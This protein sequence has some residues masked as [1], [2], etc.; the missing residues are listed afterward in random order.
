MYSIHNI[1]KDEAPSQLAEKQPVDM[2]C[3]FDDIPYLDCPPKC[4]QYDDEHEVEIEVECSKKSA[5]CHW[6]EEDYLQFRYDNQPLH[7]SHD[8]DEEETENFRVREKSLPLCFPS[9]KFLRRNCKQVVNGREG[10]CSDQLGEDASANVEVVLNPEL[11]PFTYFDFQIPNEILKPEAN[12]ELIQNNYVPL[13]FNSFQILKETLGQVL[14]DKYIKGQEIS[15]ESMQQSCQSFQDPIVDQ[16]DGLCGQN[17][18]PSSSYGIKRRYDMDMIGHSA[19]GVCSAEASFQ[20][21]SG[22]LQPY[23]EMHEDENNIDTVPKHVTYL[24]E[25]K[26]QGTCHFYLDP[27][28]TYMENFF[29]IEPQSISSITL[30]LP[31]SR[32]LYCKDQSCFQQRPLH[33]A[34]LNLW[35]KGHTSLFTV[36]TSSQ[37]ILWSQQLLDWLHWHFCII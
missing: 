26:N 15:F 4:D 14:K 19:T 33:F 29:T 31:N 23:Q 12:Y 28:A 24:A 11:Q 22:N 17:H 20:N 8:S 37:T 27:I 5:A 9:F 25:S 34:V 32:G 10:E 3:M 16:L 35:A 18:S 7:N 13:C 2:M 36:L 21:S 30:V 6:Q 1:V